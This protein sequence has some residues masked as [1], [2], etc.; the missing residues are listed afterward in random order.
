MKTKTDKKASSNKTNSPF[1]MAKTNSGFFKVQPKLNVGQPGDKYEK[2]ADAVAEKITTES[3][4][5][6][7]G[8]FRS[9]NSSVQL[10]SDN[11][12]QEKLLAENITSLIQKQEEEEELLQL[13]LVQKQEEE[14]EEE[15]IQPQ[16]LEEGEELAQMQ[17]VEEEEE[18]IRAKQNDQ[19]STESSIEN[20]IKKSSGK[21]SKMD[22]SIRTEMENGFGTDFGTVNIHTDSQAAQMNAELGAQ[23]FTHGNDVYFNKGKYNPVSNVGKHLLAHELTHTIQQS[24]GMISKKESTIFRATST[25]VDTYVKNADKTKDVSFK[26]NN[27]KIVVKPDSKTNKK[28]MENKAETTF[29]IRNNSSPGAKT[30]N[31]KISK[32]NS[33]PAPA[34]DIQTVYGKKVTSASKSAYGKGTTAADLKAGKTS[35]GYHEGSHGTDY[36]T[37]IKNN[38]IPQFAGTVGMTVKEYKKAQAEYKK[39]WKTYS[40]RMDSYS[41]N[42]TDCVGTKAS[43]CPKTP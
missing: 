26:V 23:A 24:T 15:L 36:L 22:S 28:A 2:E 32:I 5:E 42:L 39:A 18:E 31:G 27:V 33:V 25:P 38:P 19:T 35:L 34:I 6:N 41:E 17:P 11:V 40:S 8:F 4:N 9:A 7:Q 29:K 14:E 43:F 20:E 37:F 30:L 21:G 3:Q 16:P 12:M 13:K 10:Q 1:F